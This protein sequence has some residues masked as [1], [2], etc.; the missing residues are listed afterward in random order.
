MCRASR[1]PPDLTAE[2][3][4]A[5]LAAFD[6][7]GSRRSGPSS[8]RSRSE[9]AARLGVAHACALSSGTAALHLALLRLGVGPGD[10]VSCRR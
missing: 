9:V 2:E 10:E 6:S 8:T 7:G 1:F 4:E 5:L 3:R